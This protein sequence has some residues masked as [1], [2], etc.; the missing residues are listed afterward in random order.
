MKFAK[1]Y[2]TPDDN[3]IL[4]IVRY[5]EEMVVL[6]A[7]TTI[8]KTEFIFEIGRFPNDEMVQKLYKNLLSKEMLFEIYETMRDKQLYKNK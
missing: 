2:D 1:L 7:I 8:N 3:Q 5:R 6:E 4:G